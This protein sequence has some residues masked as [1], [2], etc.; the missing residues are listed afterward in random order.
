MKP[1]N[2][3]T[4]ATLLG[5]MLLLA[6]VMAPSARAQELT[7]ISV[8][9]SGELSQIGD[10]NVRIFIGAFAIGDPNQL[11]GRGANSV[12]I[13]DPTL[14]PPDPCIWTLTGAVE[15]DTFVA[16]L[17]GS[18]TACVNARFVGAF[19]SLIADPRTG[20]IAFSLGDFQFTGVGNVV[21][22][23]PNI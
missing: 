2:I 4:L 11:T 9:I 17:A 10:P 23:S 20:E 15:P 14:F 12:S 16:R 6:S 21:V 19:V 13:G 22:G 8:S 18:T 1:M 3:G 5:T 7:R